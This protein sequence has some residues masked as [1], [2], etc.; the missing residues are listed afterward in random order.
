MSIQI[1]ENIEVLIEA[2][3]DL[4]VIFDSNGKVINVSQN[5]LD[6]YNIKDKNYFIGK[7]ISDFVVSEQLDELQ[8]NFKELL[9]KRYTKKKVYKLLKAD[10]SFFHGELNSK[11]IDGKKDGEK[12]FI[13]VI[14]DITPQ[15]ALLR[16][17]NNSKQMFQLVLDNIPQHI[18]WKDIKSK[19]LGCNKNF[20]RVAGV[21]EPENIVGKTDYDLAWKFEEAESFY[22]IERLVME[23][24]KPEFHVIESQLQADGKQA[25]LDVN[26][27][28]L[29]D[30]EGIVIGLLGTYEDITERKFSEEKLKE[31]EEKFRRIFEAI[32][33]LFF[34]ISSEGII[35]DY[36]TREIELYVSPEQFLNKKVNDVLPESLA[37]SL[38]DNIGRTLGT[39]EPTIL[40]YNLPISKE[41]K[42]FEARILYFSEKQVAVFIRDITENKNA[43][44][45]LIQ[46]KV[47]T[48]NIDEALC[49][50]DMDGTITFLNPA[51]E[52]LTGYDRGELIGISG[53]DAANMI[54]AQKS[55]PLILDAFTK[56]L[57]GETVKRLSFCM[58]NKDGK[59]IPTELRAFPIKDEKGE[60]IQIV[61]VLTDITEQKK[62]RKKIQESEEKFRS[63]AEQSL[64]GMY[65]FQDNKI[66]YVNKAF[67]DIFGYTIEEVID[68]ELADI[69]K[70]IHP[71]DREFALN[72]LIKKQRGDK[73]VIENYQYRGIT[74]SSEIKWVEVFSKTIN[75]EGKPA[76]FITII[77]I[78]EKKEAEEKLIEL[79][80]IRKELITR[81]SHELRTPLT[82]VYGVSQFLLKK[83]PALALSEEIRPYIEIS[84]RGVLRLKELIDNLLDA[85]R[86]D[87]Q[88]L[89][90]RLEEI[91]LNTLI[92]D[93]VK[94][95][96]Y[97]ASSRNLTLTLD[98]LDEIFYNLDKNRISQ[99]IINLISNA[100][101]NTPSGGDIYIKVVESDNFFDIIIEDTGIGIT[102]EEKQRLFQKFG[103]I[104]R[105]GQ[106]FDVDIEG[107]GLGLYIS[108][109]IVELHGG[110]ILVESEGRNRG[111][112]FIIRFFK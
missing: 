77:D 81:I 92:N 97:L 83:A 53:V 36:K 49:L 108:K 18:F 37:N 7:D 38:L 59:E 56:S 30:S 1:N 106:Q 21:G 65:I 99:V 28:P 64:L 2:I 42:Y 75:Y 98:L 109:E 27:I 50:F 69:S 22:E 91:N 4:V 105:Y 110:Q 67:V 73:D 40:E 80:N 78:A 41:I 62:A 112:K 89:E 26:R 85:S 8:E 13:T 29:Y 96:T 33:D 35:L 84:H 45:I 70:T 66:K 74:K 79:D 44:R 54:V 47:I 86:L 51:F 6:F 90:L 103:K 16:E 24:R 34:L 72:Q 58:Q 68:W 76:D 48:D 104:E 17:L 88:K 5:V 43:E 15:E 55:I 87:I 111:A 93:C 46:S 25:W 63:F 32:P 107:A 100:I 10:G 82:S 14:R 102:N 101:K 95:L 9:K 31:S 11:V 3:P 60:N 23:S 12:L 61:A 57:K 52:K 19:Y 71:D 20:A 39:K 94:E